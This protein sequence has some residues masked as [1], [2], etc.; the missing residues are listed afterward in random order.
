[1]WVIPCQVNTKNGRPLQIS[2]KLGL[3]VVLHDLLAQTEFWLQK[4][5]GFYFTALRKL[6][7]SC[8]FALPDLMKQIITSVLP[9]LLDNSNLKV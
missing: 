1:M 5:C 3:Q 4:L 7:F 2:T 9:H 6:D 8:I